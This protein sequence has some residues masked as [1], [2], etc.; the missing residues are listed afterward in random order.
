MNDENSLARAMLARIFD[1]Q[2]WVPG[3]DREHTLD[4]ACRQWTHGIS[5]TEA[6]RRTKEIMER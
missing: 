4:V 1:I 3:S 6:V 5:S 2:G